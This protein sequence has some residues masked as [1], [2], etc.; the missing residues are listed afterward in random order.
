MGEQYVQNLQD[1]KGEQTPPID[2]FE[3]KY[4]FLSNF[5][6]HV[7]KVKYK[8]EEWPTAEHAF[9]AAKTQKPNQKLAI[10]KCKTPGQAKRRGGSR[11]QTTLRIGWD[12]AKQKIMLDIV[13]SKFSHPQLKGLL[14]ATGDAE[15]IEG[16][17]WN[18]K[19]WGVCKGVGEN[20]LG[21]I[22]MQVRGE[23]AAGKE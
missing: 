23:L 14:L 18:D 17:T 6:K 16:N 2:C 22:L 12:N 21:K 10:L 11:T 19:Y 1:I 5:F 7:K 20:H 13:R 4:A 8:Y 9:Q 3:G 15:L